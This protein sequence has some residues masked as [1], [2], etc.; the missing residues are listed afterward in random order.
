MIAPKPLLEEIKL[1]EAATAIS[2]RNF[3]LLLRCWSVAIKVIATSRDFL[4]LH[5]RLVSTLDARA[6]CTTSVGAK[7]DHRPPLTADTT[8]KR[9][10]A[11][12]AEDFGKRN[13]AAA[14][15]SIL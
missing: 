9:A 12:S 15:I 1:R 3:L 8:V 7:R 13:P 4:M 5:S 6:R 14:K 11:G 2:G 10:S